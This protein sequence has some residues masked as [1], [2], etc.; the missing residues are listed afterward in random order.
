MWR[1]Q[2]GLHI[3]K[4]A[5]DHTWEVSNL[6]RSTSDRV[7]VQNDQPKRTNLLVLLIAIYI[8]GLRFEPQSSHL[9]A[10]KV[11]FLVT[12]LLHPKNKK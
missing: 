10:L 9:S 12:K 6:Y 4:L 8:R 3:T 11:K 2:D 1:H 5:K 7:G